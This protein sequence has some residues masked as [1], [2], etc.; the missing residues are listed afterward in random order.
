MFGTIAVVWIFKE[1]GAMEGAYGLAIILNMLMTTRCW[2][3]ILHSKAFARS[4]FIYWDS[5][6][7]TGNLFLIQT[8]TSLN[9]VL[10]YVL[11]RGDLFYDDVHFVKGTSLARSSHRVVDLK[12]YV[13]DSRL[14]SR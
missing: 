4:Y 10:V 1:S 9:K 12:H 3:F 13:R 7:H 11:H 5:L 8:S 6:F 2:C 14:T